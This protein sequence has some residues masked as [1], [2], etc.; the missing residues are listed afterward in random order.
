MCPLLIN[1]STS[2]SVVHG[3]D[4]IHLSLQAGLLAGDGREIVEE[5]G[6]LSGEQY[7]C[8]PHCF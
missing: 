2:G 3:I 4:L 5:G 6:W 8:C 1:S 7:T